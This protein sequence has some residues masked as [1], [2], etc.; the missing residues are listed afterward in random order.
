MGGG[1]LR[2]SSSG[3]FLKPPQICISAQAGVEESACVCAPTQT[4][5]EKKR[6]GPGAATAA[7]DETPIK[8]SANHI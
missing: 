4:A 6:K 2:F 7:D 3:F 5:A 8:A 1:A